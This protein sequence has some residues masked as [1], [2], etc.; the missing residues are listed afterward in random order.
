MNQTPSSHWKLLF[1]LLLA[2]CLT[3]VASDLYV[4]ALPAIVKQ[5]H[6]QNAL[7][8]WTLSLYLLGV[9]LSQL[10]YGPVSE[11]WGRKHPLVIGLCIMLVGTVVCA[12]APTIT[13]LLLGRF[14]QGA[15]AGACAALWRAIF[16]DVFV[17][18]N[19]SKYGAYLTTLILFVLPAAPVIG[20]YLAN[21]LGWRS[22]FVF[23]LLYGLVALVLI[24]TQFNE[25]SQHHHRGR[26]TLAQV[27]HSYQTLL[28]HRVFMGMTIATFLTY[29]ALFTWLTT[30]PMLMMQTLHFSPVEFGWINFFAAGL[31]YAI[32][33][34]LNGV[35]VK[36]LGI[37]TLIRL[38][39]LI[40][41]L[42]AGFLFS[43]A[44]LHHTAVYAILI[45][46][47]LLYF[48]STWVLPNAFATA[49][50]PFGHI[51]GYAGALYG[52]MQ[53][54]G[55]AVLSGLMGYLPTDST[56]PLG[57]VVGAA[58]LG[59]WAVYEGTVARTR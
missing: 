25:T 41:L 45:G 36:K 7:V 10:V 54:C 40:M 35:W 12:C 18:E 16:R 39:W 55:G 13:W 20:G 3:Q 56:L 4:P 49:F 9:A 53:I 14:I 33:G 46:V 26:L 34:W 22:N 48:G 23:M 59:A 11:G 6:T 42:S 43:A 50:T 29:G 32:A 38:G 51:A 47:V 21:G 28:T 37:A 57:L 19:L 58:T 15:G 31:P 52:F 30:G 5:L 44:F 1:V 27:R 24:V 2:V 8:Q 17:G